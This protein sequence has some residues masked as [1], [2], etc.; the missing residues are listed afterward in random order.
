[1]GMSGIAE[2]KICGD[3]HESRFPGYVR[4][5]RYGR[6]NSDK[7]ER[8]MKFCA[9][10]S[11]IGF[12]AFFIFTVLAIFAPDDAPGAL[13]ADVVLAAIGFFAGIFSWLK[14]KRG[15]C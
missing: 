4:P 12:G 8:R 10:M 14:V 15:T 13:M 9:I 5:A 6:A 1:M 3:L 2:M 11:V 7:G